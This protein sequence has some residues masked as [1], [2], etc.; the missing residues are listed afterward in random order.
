M[1]VGQE[2]GAG[3]ISPA[4]PVSPK[5]VLYVLLGAHLVNDF[6]STVLP[7]FLPAV[8]DEFDLDYTE[9]G[10]LAF[11]FTLLTGVLQPLL[12]NYADRTGRRRGVLIF[13]FV[14]GAL[15]FIAMAAAPSFWFIVVVSTLVGL[16][17]ATYHPQATAFIVTA[18]PKRRGRMLG[19]HGWGG[20]AG[21][22]LAPAVVVLVVAALDWRV[23]M[24]LI[25]LP[26]AI[27]AVVLRVRLPATDPSPSATMR[28]ALTRP[29]VLVAITFAVVG[30][31]GRSFLNFFVKMLVDEGWAETD[32]GVLLTVILMGGAISQP[33]GGLAYDRF[34]GRAVVTVAAASTAVLIA[35]FAVTDG[36]TSLVAVAGITFFQFSLFPVGLAQASELAASSQTGAATGVVFGVSGLL[37]AALQPVV[38][39]V[40][41]A[42]D[43][44]RVALAWL[45]PLAV[46]GI[47]LARFIPTA[48][49]Q[50]SDVH[51]VNLD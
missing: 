15:G 8:A 28:G 38:G 32:A 31:G 10:I 25:A 27:A 20:S 51:P 35:V 19:I 1:T 48:S 17:G 47:V 11:S 22:F 14:V 3:P 16:G 50:M 5:T 33:L 43:D 41:E 46:L 42:A 37:T 21:H 49:A 12:G 36:A 23:A 29:L 44:I 4:S 39:A 13:G 24:T 34:G 2:T 6:S 9:L 45:L 40:A 18:F 26:M 7:A 30:M